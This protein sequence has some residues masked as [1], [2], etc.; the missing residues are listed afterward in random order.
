MSSTALSYRV[1]RFARVSILPLTVFPIKAALIQSSGSGNVTLDGSSIAGYLSGQG[2]ELLMLAGGVGALNVRT[3]FSVVE[4]GAVN[5]TSGPYILARD[6]TGSAAVYS[7]LLLHFDDT[8]S[9]FKS[10]TPLSDGNFTVISATFDTDSSPWIGAPSRIHDLEKDKSVFPL[11]GVRVSVKD[12]YFL[13]GLRS[14]AGNRHY[15]TTYPPRNATGPAVQRLMQAGAHIVG[16]TKTVQFANGDRATADWVDYHASFVQRGDGNREPGGSSTGGGTSISSADWLDVSIGSDTGGSIRSPSGNNG[17]YGIRPSVGAI[18][19]DDVLPL[20]DVLDTGGFMARD[21]HLFSQFG[22]AWYSGSFQSFP[23]FPQQILLSD[24]FKSLSANASAV[25][26]DFFGKLRTFLGQNATIANFSIPA[27]WNQTSE[28]GVSV[29]KLLNETYPI[30][31]G[32]HQWTTVGQPFFNDFAA[33]NGGRKPHI[34]PGVL[35]RWNFAQSQGEGVFNQELINRETFENWTMKHFLTENNQS[36]SDSLY[37]YPQNAGQY[38]SR[39]DYYIAP[40]GPPFGFSDGRVAVH[41]RTPDMVVPIG[42]IPYM[43]SIT[44]IEEVLPVTVSIVARRGC[45]FTLL[46][47]V[48]ALADRG[49]VQ[50]VKTGRTAF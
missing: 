35:T 48:S 44:G 43:S 33:A 42:Q 10:V 5:L 30:L 50:T 24:S 39:E 36:C 47:L 8:Q 37:L 23:S 19:L 1:S 49:I 18:S 15:Y 25:Y 38:V 3:N 20:S 6:A 29:N 14:S 31:I 40:P 2:T 9:F 45:D 22:K 26:D 41:A 7:P 21:P 16:T 46:D 27:Q 34:N 12:I 17:V 28:T 4:L 32:W 13:K 11:A